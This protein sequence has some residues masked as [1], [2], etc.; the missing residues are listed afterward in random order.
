MTKYVIFPSRAY[1]CVAVLGD[2]LYVMG[3]YTVGPTPLKTEEQYDPKRN[4]WS[5]IAPM[6]V[7]RSRAGATALNGNTEHCE[8]GGHSHTVDS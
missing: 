7:E 5:P 4:R 6:T 2:V 3:G 1:H 8:T